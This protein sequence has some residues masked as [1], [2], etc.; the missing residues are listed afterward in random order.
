MPRP[1]RF[2]DFSLAVTT[3]EQ[4]ITVTDCII[5]CEPWARRTRYIVTLQYFWPDN[6]QISYR[7][8]NVNLTT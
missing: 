6:G 2:G 3:P 7:R 4:T 5:I 8:V 1:P